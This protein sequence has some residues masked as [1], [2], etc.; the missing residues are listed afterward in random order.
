MGGGE[1]ERREYGFILNHNLVKIL[2]GLS[3]P[4]RTIWIGLLYPIWMNV[5]GVWFYFLITIE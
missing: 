3:I 2:A 5:E 4:Y 1:G